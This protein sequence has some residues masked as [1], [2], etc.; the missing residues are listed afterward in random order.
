WL[1]EIKKYYPNVPVLLVGTKCDLKLKAKESKLNLT[2]SD[3]IKSSLHTSAISD[4]KFPIDSKKLS[5]ELISLKSSLHHQ[6]IKSKSIQDRP[7]SMISKMSREQM[8]S[9]TNRIDNRSIDENLKHI[10]EKL[11]SVPPFLTLNEFVKLNLLDDEASVK[12]DESTELDS[13]SIYNQYVNKK[14]INKLKEAVNTKYYFKTSCFEINSIRFLMDKAIV[15]AINFHIKKDRLPFR[16]SRSNLN[17]DMVNDKNEQNAD[18][19]KRTDSSEAVNRE[20]AK[21]NQKKGGLCKL[22]CF[23]CTRSETNSS[24]NQI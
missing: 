19:I 20:K 15:T 17:N 24:L 7:I 2:K 8:F 3:S 1:P 5:N 21:K 6:L 16:Q 14:Q 23:S 12:L 10:L 22:R 11:N 18:L 13:S 4:S 9:S